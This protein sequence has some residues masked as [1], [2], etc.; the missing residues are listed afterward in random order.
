[1]SKTIRIRTTPNGGDNY[2]KV[3]IDQE[4]DYLETLSLKISQEEAYRN[5]C[6]DYGV[7]IGRV[8]VNNGFGVP[9]AKVS[10]FVPIDD[11]DKENPLIKSLYPY[12]IV[13]DRD[14][15][16]IRY[17]LFPKNNEK[18]DACFTPIGTMP[19][20]REILDNPE[21]EYI[22]TKYY[23]FTATTNASG[24][25]MLFGVPVGT[26]TIHSDVDISDIGM[27]SQKPYDLIAAGTPEKFFDSAQKFKYSKNLDSLVQV[28]SLNTSVNVQPFWGDTETCEIGITRVDLDMNLNIKSNAIFIGSIFGDSDTDGVSNRCRPRRI[29]GSLCEQI[30]TSG[31]IEMIRE[32]PDGNIERFDVDG[33]ELIDEDGTWAYQLPMNLDYVVTDEFG[34][35]V[36]SDNPS[37]GIATRANVR[38]RIGMSSAG[39]LDKRTR[40]N[41]LVPNNPSNQ[42]EIDYEF[43]SNT[44]ATSFRSL[45][46]NKIYTV[47]SF[48]SRFQASS[49]NVRNFV[50]VKDVNACT[51]DKNPFPYNRVDSSGDPLYAFLCT[52]LTIMLFILVA[53][54]A[55]LIP[56]INFIVLLLN[57]I[58]GII[59][60]IIY[61]IGALLG[62]FPSWL[63]DVNK[64]DFCIAKGTCCDCF[65]ILPYAPCL[66]ILCPSTDGNVYAPGCYKKSLDFGTSLSKLKQKYDGSKTVFYPGDGVNDEFDALAGAD[67]CLQASLAE[68]LNVFRFDFYNDW[69]NGALYAF[70]I[71]YK[72]K[73]NGRTR[74]CEYDCEDFQGS[75][76]Y[77]GVDTDR[78]NGP[79]NRCFT[80]YLLDSC[81]DG[82]PTDIFTMNG[83]EDKTF[84]SGGI[85]DGV[86]KNVEVFF[87]ETK[88]ED[89]LYYAS[90]MHD[91]KYKLFAT[92]IVLLGSTESCDWQG[93]PSLYKLL[94]TTSYKLPST[95][96]EY[97]DPND[98]SS[99]LTTGMVELNSKTPGLFFSINCLGIA[100]D[101]KQC[102]NVR[103]ICEFGATT[104]DAITVNG[105]TIRPN[106]YLDY[107]DID[108]DTGVFFRDI[109]YSLNKDLTYLSPS[110]PRYKFP[111]T[112]YNTNFNTQNLPTYDYNSK[113]QNGLE[114]AN[115]RG[116]GGKNMFSQP[117]HS[118]FFY[119]GTKPGAS[120]I[121]KLNQRYFGICPIITT[122][123]LSIKAASVGASITNPTGSII[124]SVQFGT[125][126][127]AYSISGP[128][129]Y[130]KKGT[131]NSSN[132]NLSIPNLSVG[133][134]T[135][136]VVD[137][138]GNSTKQTATIAGPPKLSASASVS[139][140]AT[141][142]TVGDGIIL[143]TGVNG[144]CGGYTYELFNSDNK[145]I[146]TGSVAVTQIPFE[147]K[148]LLSDNKGS[149]YRL[150]IKDSCNA[151]VE[152]KDLKVTGPTPLVI[153]E[154]HVD[155]QCFGGKSS[156]S[157]GIAVTVSGGKLPYTVN[158]TGP[159]GYSN[160]I[161]ST[162]GSNTTF[163]ELFAGQYNITVT[164]AFNSSSNTSAIIKHLTPELKATKPSAA[165]LAKQCDPNK[166]IIPIDIASGVINNNVYIVYS[167]A[168]N[169]NVIIKPYV[170]NQQTYFDL[171]S[172]ALA[173]NTKMTVYLANDQFNGDPKLRCI[174]EIS[175]WVNINKSEIELPNVALEIKDRS[176]LQQCSRQTVTVKFGIS[177]VDSGGLLGA[178]TKRFPYTLKYKI[179]NGAEKTV[180]I[181]NITQLSL[182]NG[183]LTYSFVESLG[184]TFTGTNVKVNLTLI[185]KVGCETAK[186]L[187][188]I[189]PAV[190]L[191]GSINRTSTVTNNI[192]YCEY[193]ISANGGIGTI[194]PA[195]PYSLNT[196]YQAG[197]GQ[198]CP[199][200][201]SVS[202]SVSDS[203]GCSIVIKG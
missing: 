115:F 8:I 63:L 143:I 51:G 179:N 125:A 1:M 21:L 59:C 52:L 16:G 32:T 4:F 77:S 194:T 140:N 38:F 42:S 92:D 171:P 87:K 75:E 54:N 195:A 68:A 128:N 50:G 184:T 130:L 145:S 146:T 13:T 56:I 169:D 37:I 144:G 156:T 98:K 182:F 47:S 27:A 113:T 64:C 117:Q 107:R 65:E 181:S 167:I 41:F 18:N 173:N 170:T 29:M 158:V 155:I 157:E 191:N 49:L 152:I 58:L 119:F 89:V 139:K 186:E 150:V 148:N 88:V 28:K 168:G 53:I 17:N 176:N 136:I 131:I 60:S 165:L 24:D 142:A 153:T 104:D 180:T 96:V 73:R 149:G 101:Y 78:E 175:T 82:D 3:K 46:W 135:I 22:F 5:F 10:I 105:V 44:K 202:I 185:D 35:L 161:I 190:E 11:E 189:V 200:P 122:D 127:Y 81:Y 160:S 94:Q 34:Q 100:M 69:V 97:E 129:G 103:H 23:K 109:F 6:S 9:N 141:N 25:F 76:G 132:T 7:V 164:D 30:T 14:L 203:V 67:D 55:V 126:P 174:Q 134:Y 166:Y 48:I 118:Y 93:M 79:D 20:K 147:I 70:L 196:P 199:S 66:S 45:Y 116:Y 123:A 106:G 36:P 111:T 151:I 61:G 198:S 183:D 83:S 39:D 197:S 154:K 72:K 91:A 85:K 108:D 137:K 138:N 187:N 110:A 112:P 133:T 2:L 102:L 62:A 90:S 74:F 172:S 193:K 33:G 159:K 163:V 12:E 114:Y 84:D 99:V 57:G 201:S 124:F 40:A 121:E 15:D 26:H 95:T 120:A 188:I 31:R 71:Q 178:Y 162:D 19:S 177:H 192:K 80:N 86:L 43:G